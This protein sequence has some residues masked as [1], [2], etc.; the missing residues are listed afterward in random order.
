MIAN[1]GLQ[2]HGFPIIE[3]TISEIQPPCHLL[4]KSSPAPTLKSTSLPSELLMPLM[5]TKIPKF[6]KSLRFF[7]ANFFVVG[8]TPSLFC[9]GFSTRLP[10]ERNQTERDFHLRLAVGTQLRRS[11][12]PGNPR[13]GSGCPRRVHCHWVRKETTG[14]KPAKAG[15]ALN[16]PPANLSAGR[17]RRFS[18][19]SESTV[20]GEV[21]FSL[22]GSSSGKLKYQWKPTFL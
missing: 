9:L 22:L 16:L 11:N 21:F 18:S 12:P 7:G 6:L 14:T 20:S 4:K 19:I 5:P 10:N 1:Y 3:P 15:S 17:F 8:K 2:K 13:F